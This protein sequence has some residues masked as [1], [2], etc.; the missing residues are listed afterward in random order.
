VNR[1]ANHI[2]DRKPDELPGQVVWQAYPG[3]EGTEIERRFMRA[4]HQREKGSFT[5]YYANHERWY[6]ITVFPAAEGISVFFC[7]VTEQKAMQAERNALMAESERLRRMYETALDSTS[8]FVSV[9][10]LEHRLI[11]ANVPLVTAW[12]VDD[13]R[14][15][16]WMELG[17]EQ[18]HAELHD[19]EIDAV[20][21]TRAPVCGELPFTGTGGTR[22]YDCIFAPVLGKR[23]DVVAVAGTAR[24]IPPCQY[25][26]LHLPLRIQ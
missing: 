17:Y 4:M 6:E 25:D 22:L 12:G 9:F 23:G 8:D 15:K 24:D 11:Y 3:L 16:R 5:A 18:W 26:L 13:A 21:A 10:D 1:E 20:I 14:G 2:L 7:D 19:R